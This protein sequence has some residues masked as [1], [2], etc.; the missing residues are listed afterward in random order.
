MELLAAH[1]VDNYVVACRAVPAV[2]PLAGQSPFLFL[3]RRNLLPRQAA[4]FLEP[5]AERGQEALL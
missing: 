1:G 4:A 5:F 2:R 3:F